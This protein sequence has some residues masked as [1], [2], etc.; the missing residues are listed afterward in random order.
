[1]TKL[2][3]DLGAAE[4]LSENHE[5]EL[6]MMDKSCNDKVAK[7]QKEVGKH[8]DCSV[9]NQIVF[10]VASD[11]SIKRTRERTEKV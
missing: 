8:W 11:G 7:A 5:Q 4:K 3:N 1:M 9:K 6:N 2:D 10:A